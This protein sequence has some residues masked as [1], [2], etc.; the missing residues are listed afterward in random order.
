MLFRMLDGELADVSRRDYETRAEYCDALM[1]VY[2]VKQQVFQPREN[3]NQVEVI[4]G[5]LM[6]HQHS[7]L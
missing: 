6:N 3:D 2:G 5:L 1:E 7:R 4:Y